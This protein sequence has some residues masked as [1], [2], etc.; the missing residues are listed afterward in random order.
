MNLDVLKRTGGRARRH[1]NRL[2]QATWGARWQVDT[3]FHHRMCTVVGFKK[4]R[5]RQ[6][7]QRK[8]TTQGIIQIQTEGI[9]NGNPTEEVKINDRLVRTVTGAIPRSH[10][11][12]NNT[13]LLDAIGRRKYDGFAAVCLIVHA[14]NE[15]VEQPAVPRKMIDENR[16]RVD[17]KNPKIG[18]IACCQVKKAI[19]RIGHDK[20][21]R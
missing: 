17:G 3:D 8:N 11:E 13:A 14:N 2:F 10:L 19:A 7:A 18:A 9:R 16:Q 4:N 1:L 21:H 20:I 15:G 5:Q 6:L 12:V